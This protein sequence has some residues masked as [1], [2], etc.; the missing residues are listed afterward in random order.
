MPRPRAQAGAGGF[1]LPRC[2]C[3]DPAPGQ[4]A[5]VIWTTVTVFSPM[6]MTA[7]T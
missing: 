1:R 4:P 2:F 7:V 6:R 5:Y 3:A